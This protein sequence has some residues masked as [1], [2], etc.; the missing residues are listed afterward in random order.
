MGLLE[1]MQE[2]IDK[3][4]LETA[5]LKLKD[6]ELDIKI[7]NSNQTIA[8][9]QTRVTELENK[10]PPVPSPEPEPE[11]IP[12]PTPEPLPE[13]QPT[14]VPSAKY[15]SLGNTANLNSA[16]GLN[17]AHNTSY[18]THNMFVDVFMTARPWLSGPGWDVTS[19]ITLDA[20]GWPIS[21][22]AG[23]F[24][25]TVILD[26]PERK[27]GTYVVLWDGDGDI[28]ISG[29][30]SAFVKTSPTR[31]T[32]SIAAGSGLVDFKITRIGTLKNI[33]IVHADHEASHWNRF[34]DPLSDLYS[35]KKILFNPDYVKLHE[36]SR[37]FRFMDLGKTNSSPI[38]TWASRPT[39]VTAIQT[40]TS[41]IAMEY[42]IAL[43]NLVGADPWY[44]VPHKADDNYVA[45]AAA[46]WKRDLNPGLNV[47]VEYS[48]ETWNGQFAQAGYVQ[49]RGVADGLS[50]VRWDAGR[51]YH[52]SRSQRVGDTFKATFGGT[53]VVRVLGMQ[54]AGA[55]WTNKILA[56]GKFKGEA[57]AHAPYVGG[58][59]QT[60]LTQD[61][62]FAALNST[63]MAKAVGYM[64]ENAALGTKYGVQVLGYEGG[65]H[66]VGVGAQQDP[67]SSQFM[68]ANTDPR[69]GAVYKT[70][71]DAWRANGGGLMMLF[72][73]IGS[74]AK[75]GSWGMREQLSK[76]GPKW[77]AYTAWLDA[78]SCNWAGCAR[79]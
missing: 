35:G 51:Y 57:I 20:N 17:L 1:T 61:Q 5:N 79:T 23:F 21:A 55:W 50:T 74:R 68:T 69:M 66:L 44:C 3:N 39:P 76:D 30:T 28:S 52:A 22:A 31:G 11:P 6:T 26:N 7:Q 8:T 42:M 64:K 27:A 45:Q 49:D 59:L 56:E 24:P 33:R 78:N 77:A 36:K 37:A 16:L 67:L 40:S 41:G 18:A 60:A 48:N 73:N 13:P 38:T 4:A 71:L 58:E 2:Q 14:P 54:A 25:H 46:L 43:S 32:V 15:S 47:Y 65:Q 10:T 29:G 53:R 72:N 62:I 34:K 9:L 75:Y 12:D 70:Y 63:S 19:S